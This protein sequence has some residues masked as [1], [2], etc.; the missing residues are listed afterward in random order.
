LDDIDVGDG[1]EL[2]MNIEYF[3]APNL[4]IL[5]PTLLYLVAYAAYNFP[6]DVSDGYRIQ[7]VLVT[8]LR[9]W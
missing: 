9:C 8:I 4:S 5:S 1:C 7:N 3:L 6:I 2:T